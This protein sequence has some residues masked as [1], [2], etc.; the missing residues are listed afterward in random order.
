[1]RVII[2]W[3]YTH[4]QSLLLSQLMH[5]SST[6]SLVVFSAPRASPR[7]EVTWFVVYGCV[8]W[9]LVV[10]IQKKARPTAVFSEERTVTTAAQQ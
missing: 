2:A 9:L 6:G 10:L 8:L 5:V 4:K 1:M 3:L 7:Q